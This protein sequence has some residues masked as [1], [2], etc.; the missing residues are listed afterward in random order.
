MKENDSDYNLYSRNP[1]KNWLMFQL[2]LTPLY[3]GIPINWPIEERNTSHFPQA[4]R[5]HVR[6]FG[7]V[8][9]WLSLENP[10]INRMTESCELFNQNFY[11]EW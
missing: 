1:P 3:V 8:S 2:L 6:L 4:D 10:L 9:D 5:S 7:R 11:S